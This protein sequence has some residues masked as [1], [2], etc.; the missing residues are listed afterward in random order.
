MPAVYLA[1]IRDL[2]GLQATLAGTLRRAW[3]A[4]YD[5]SEHTSEHPGIAALARLEAAVLSLL[6]GSVEHL[7]N[8]CQQ[9]E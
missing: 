3:A 6:Q 5:L 8:N 1:A 7:R 4:G 9:K 2:P